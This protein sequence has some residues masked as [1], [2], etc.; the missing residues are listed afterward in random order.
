M[1]AA[2]EKW[3]PHVIV[4]PFL[5]KRVPDAIFTKVSGAERVTGSGSGFFGALADVWHSGSRWLCTLDRPGM[6]DH[7]HWIGYC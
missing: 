4:C 5:T 7:P 1:I 3:D 6:L 2:A